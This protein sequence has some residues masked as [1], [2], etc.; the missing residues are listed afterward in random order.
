MAMSYRINA[1]RY[2]EASAKLR[3]N[4]KEVF[5]TAVRVS[6]DASKRKKHRCIIM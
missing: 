1:F 2:V 6:L 5:E 4:L 3:R